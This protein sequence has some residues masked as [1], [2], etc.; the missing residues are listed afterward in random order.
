MGG[1][2]TTSAAN[3]S[4][5]RSDNCELLGPRALLLVVTS[6]PAW[7]TATDSLA[8]PAWR[9]RT[10]TDEGIA[11]RQTTLIAALSS[12]YLSIAH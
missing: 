6:S 12:S 7:I 2:M 11:A 9:Q 1:R 10:T 5:C 8:H 3:T 4:K